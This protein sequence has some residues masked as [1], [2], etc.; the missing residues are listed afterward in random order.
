MKTVKKIKII[1]LAKICGILGGGLYLSAGLLINIAALLLGL[2]A[3]QGFNIL[4]F[5]S[6]LLATLLVAVLIGAVAFILG[7]IIAW[8][9]NLAAA[10]AGGLTWEE[11]ESQSGGRMFNKKPVQPVLPPHLAV[12]QAPQAE[13]DNIINISAKET[14]VS[15]QDPNFLS[16]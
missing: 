14:N 1:S 8:L 5:G 11:T 6:G 3:M 16:S 10:L 13:V 15:G 4:G 2:P 9:Y 12:N 7:G